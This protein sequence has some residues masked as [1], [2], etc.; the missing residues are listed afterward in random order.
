MTASPTDRPGDGPADGVT[1][2]AATDRG[3][4]AR[5]ALRWDAAYCAVAGVAI[6]AFT[7]SIEQHL[8]VS[9]WIVATSGIA[10]VVW[11]GVLAWLAIDDRWRRSATIAAVANGV[12]AVALAYWAVTRGGRPGAILGFLAAQV[13]GFGLAQAWALLER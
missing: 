6:A 2:R 9:G 7:S 8:E 5:Q 1:H 11:A 4:F 3:A 10:I 12:A 13:A